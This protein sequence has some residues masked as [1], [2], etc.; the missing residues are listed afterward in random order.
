MQIELLALVDAA[1]G[2]DDGI[3]TAGRKLK[4]IMYDRKENKKE[5]VVEMTEEDEMN[6]RS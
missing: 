2:P 5:G 6:W 1:V 3:D 4:V